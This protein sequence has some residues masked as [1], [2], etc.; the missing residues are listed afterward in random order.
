M[1]DSVTKEVSSISPMLQATLLRQIEAIATHL[2]NQN[3][4]SAWSAL[5]TLYLQAPPRVKQ[6]VKPMFDDVYEMLREISITKG[7][8][9]YQTVILR[10]KQRLKLIQ[11]ASRPLY[12]R[13]LESFYTNKYLESY[14][15]TTTSNVNAELAAEMGLSFG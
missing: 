1:S 10:G 11:I 12:G 15:K 9:T 5:D 3:F 7:V 2:D 6:D 13:I 4:L 14:R 8:T